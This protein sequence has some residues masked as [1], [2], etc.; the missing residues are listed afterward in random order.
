MGPYWYLSNILFASTSLPSSCFPALEL[1]F[2]FVFNHDI[3]LKLLHSTMLLL[4]IYVLYAVALGR[5]V[6]EGRQ[7]P[8]VLGNSSGLGDMPGGSIVRLCPES[9][10]TDV[11]AIERIVN[12]PQVPILYVLTRI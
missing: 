2:P 9:R 1:I 12:S 5:A 6:K 8:L 11:L 7:R 3:A 10:D 4:V